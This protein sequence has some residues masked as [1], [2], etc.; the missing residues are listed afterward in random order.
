MV[1]IVAL[2]IS[3]LLMIGFTGAF[4][5]GRR[6]R[7]Y[8]SFGAEYELVAAQYDDRRAARRELLRRAR[9][10]RTLRLKTISTDDQDY[11]AT[12]WVRVQG[13]MSHNPV[14]ALNDAAELVRDLLDARGY[15]DDQDKQ[16]ALLSVKHA[17]ALVGYRTAQLTLHQAKAESSATAT[18]EMHSAL[19]LFRVLFDG[20]LGVR[21]AAAPVRAAPAAQAVPSTQ[22]AANAQVGS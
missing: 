16:V 22:A 15:P 9:L 21:G 8:A 6:R 10:H 14:R 17:S 18:E 19:V 4:A 5:T 20:V 13:G 12:S 11:Y 1:T 7:L 3:V 2:F